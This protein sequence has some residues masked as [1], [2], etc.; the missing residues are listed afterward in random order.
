M[1]ISIIL[2]ESEKVRIGCPIYIDD[3]E[4]GK[5]E[6][7]NKET[8]EVTVNINPMFDN[9]IMKSLNSSQLIGLSSRKQP[10]KL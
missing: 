1:K 4:V 6:D 10:K 3:T 7:I 5:V 8:G 9:W 2:N